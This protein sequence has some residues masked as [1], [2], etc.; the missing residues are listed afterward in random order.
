MD[1]LSRALGELA[2]SADKPYFDSEADGH[3]AEHYYAGLG[4]S[5]AGLGTLLAETHRDKPRYSPATELYP[6]VD[7]QPDRK[8]RSI[9]TLDEYD[10][11][12]LIEEAARIHDE[13]ESLHA[14]A[15]SE[16]AVEELEPYNCEH[17]VCQSWF[18]HAEPMRGDLHHLFTCERR[19]NSFR[20]NAPYTD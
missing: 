12:E 19:C 2:A 10:P 17:V 3:A 14:T 11:A 15:A 1:L 20:G 6:W 9:Y 18:D 8:V 5:A 4:P 16:A 13:R 7:L